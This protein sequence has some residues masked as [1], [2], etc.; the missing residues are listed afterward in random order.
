[1]NKKYS[2]LEN[3]LVCTTAV[4]DYKNEIEETRAWLKQCEEGLKERA[5]NNGGEITE[6][7][8]REVFGFEK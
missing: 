8:I 4:V 7:D 2:F 6:D 1:M 5:A 3:N